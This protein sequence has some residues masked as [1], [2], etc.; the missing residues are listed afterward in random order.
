MRGL[1][2]HNADVGFGWWLVMTLGMV[3][4]WGAVIALVVW[5]LRGGVAAAHPGSAEHREPTA[6]EI[7]DRRLAEGSLDVEE[8][9]RRRRLLDDRGGTAACG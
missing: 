6:R 9:E 4:F 8:Y 5:L 1:S 7:L 3:V 2:M